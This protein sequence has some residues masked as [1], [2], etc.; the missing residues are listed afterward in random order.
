MPKVPRSTL[1]S[2]DG[3]SMPSEKFGPMSSSCMA[4]I[5][6]T[7]GVLEMRAILGTQ[8]PESPPNVRF[9]TIFN[10]EPVFHDIK[11]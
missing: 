9:G 6:G 10:N 11:N 2:S 5:S 8:F 3:L 1:K 4:S 7:G